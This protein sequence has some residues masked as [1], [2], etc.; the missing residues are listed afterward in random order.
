MSLVHDVV[1]EEQL[2][3]RPLEE[4]LF[5]RFLSYHSNTASASP[6]SE[7]RS[8]SPFED[9]VFLSYSLFIRW[10]V[11]QPLSTVLFGVLILASFS[12]CR[13]SSFAR[14]CRQLLLRQSSFMRC[15][16]QVLLRQSSFARWSRHE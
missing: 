16:R 3:L 9:F 2:F 5:L 13:Q 11:D 14:S 10:V 8:L 4:Q 7:H 15:S 6:L 1:V 12:R